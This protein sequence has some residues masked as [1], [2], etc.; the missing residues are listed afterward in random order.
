MATKLTGW[1]GKLLA[2]VFTSLVAPVLVNL[3]TRETSDKINKPDRDEQVAFPLETSQ[4][5]Y[6][7]NSFHAPS[8]NGQSLSQY[9]DAFAAPQPGQTVRIIVHGIGRTPD[10]SLQDAL[11]SALRQAS[12]SIVD[13]ASGATSCSTLCADILRDNGGL[14]LGWQELGIRKEGGRKGVFYHLEAAVEVNLTALANRLRSSNT[15]GWNDPS[16]TTPYPSP[17]PRPQIQ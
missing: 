6:S 15:T 13:A 16:Q 11:H 3:A 4:P 1:C 2:V 8:P 7:S 5:I 9:H 10:L 17:L 12:A 14:I